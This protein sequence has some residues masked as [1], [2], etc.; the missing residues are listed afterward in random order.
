MGYYYIT[1]DSTAG[2][3]SRPRR[4]SSTPTIRPTRGWPGTSPP[5][6]DGALS[7]TKWPTT[8]GAEDFHVI[9]FAE[10]LLIKAEALA[11]QN[12]LAGAVDDLQPDPGARRA[13]PPHVLGVDVTT[14]GR[15]AGG[16]RPRA[17]ARAGL[18]G[19]PLARPGADRTAIAVLGIPEFQTLFPIP[20]AERDAAPGLTQ[21]PGY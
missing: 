9:R 16:D 14:P 8:A 15:S 18:R 12:D 19:R 3:G 4:A 17:A 21:N 1:E 7:G 13:W 20:Q 5:T 2:R 6:S 11:R 10:V